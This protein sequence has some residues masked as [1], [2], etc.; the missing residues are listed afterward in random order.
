M[1]E[2]AKS[3]IVSSLTTL[4]PKALNELVVYIEFLNFRE[5]VIDVLDEENIQ[6]TKKEDYDIS[7]FA[8]MLSDLTPEEMQ[9]FDEVVKR[10]PLFADR[11]TKL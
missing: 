9:R 8:G 2:Q 5:Q 1:P 10:R 11:K 7:E 4:S 6:P 3:K